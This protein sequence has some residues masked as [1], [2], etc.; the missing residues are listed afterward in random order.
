MKKHLLLVTCLVSSVSVHSQE[1]VVNF[2]VVGL[3]Q[4]QVDANVA[5]D[6]ACT[7]ISQLATPTAEQTD[8]IDTCALVAPLDDED[9]L[10]ADIMD[11]LIPEEIFA[12]SDSLTD[13]SDLQITNIYSRIHKLQLVQTG[14]A[15]QGPTNPNPTNQNGKNRT[16]IA[17]RYLTAPESGGSAASDGALVSKLQLFASGHISAGEY[18]GAEFQQNADFNSNNLTIGLDYRLKETFIIGAG[19]GFVQN[20]MSFQGNSGEVTSDGINLTLFGTYSFLNNAYADLVVDIGTSSFEMDR[21]IDI[22][23]FTNVVS[24]AETD[25]STIALTGSLGKNFSIAGWNLGP[26]ARGSIISASVD[27]FNETVATTGTGEGLTLHVGSQSITSTTI[28]LGAQ[29]SKAFSTSKAVLVPQLNLEFQTE[30]SSDKDTL[31]AY[32]LADPDQNLITVD[33]DERDTSFLNLGLGG[34]A[35]FAGGK[36]A[37]AFLETRLQHDFLTQYWLKAGFRWEF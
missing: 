22:S 12:I 27:S 17:N 25:S 20:E 11:Q 28:A 1:L 8:L 35:I 33:G 30:A 4:N 29:V 13:A 21:A 19:I 36:S 14:L 3:N 15:G 18:D 24:S 7:A 10:L 2:N 34:S 6:N 37:F 16:E 5:L 32:F 31:D 23:G 26:Y 9:P